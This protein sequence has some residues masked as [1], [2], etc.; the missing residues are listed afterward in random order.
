[1]KKPKAKHPW[2]GTAKYSIPP[3]DYFYSYD[4]LDDLPIMSDSV[5]IDIYSFR[6]RKIK[7]EDSYD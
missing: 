6:D 3:P 7:V 4:S 1:M 5:L 2:K